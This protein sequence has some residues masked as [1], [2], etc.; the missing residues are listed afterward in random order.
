MSKR[1]ATTVMFAL[2]I[3][4]WAAQA[5]GYGGW[6]WGHHGRVTAPEMP[7]YGMFAAALCGLAGY[8]VLRRRYAQAK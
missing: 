7:S 4:P 5:Q 3:F 8:L 1:I 2:L 6:G